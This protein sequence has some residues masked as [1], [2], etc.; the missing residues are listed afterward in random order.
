MVLGGVTYGKHTCTPAHGI[1]VMEA[2]GKFFGNQHPRNMFTDHPPAYKFVWHGLRDISKAST[3]YGWPNPGESVFFS[4]GCLACELD[5]VNVSGSMSSWFTPQLLHEVRRQS[6]LRREPLFFRRGSTS[7]AIHVRRGDVEATDVK[8]GT[9]D[10]W[11]LRL[12][13]QLREIVP[14][15]DIHVFS[16]LEEQGG[17]RTLF[18]QRASDFDCYRQRNVSVHLDKNAVAHMAHFA[19]ASVAVLAKSSF[20]H[21]PALLNHNCVVYQPYWHR[22]LDGWVAAGPSERTPL[23]PEAWDA[24]AACV[25]G[26]RRP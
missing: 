19:M 22:P 14:D 9:S 12:I 7:V 24:L 25:H 23:G 18:G 20:S 3:K 15:P 17:G 8:R 11:Y 5:S 16:S 21:A 1:D 13:D 6:G 4:T 2:F 10:A 26:V